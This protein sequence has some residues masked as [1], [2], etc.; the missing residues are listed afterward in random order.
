MKTETKNIRKLGSQTFFCYLLLYLYF[1]NH[2]NQWDDENEKREQKTA[3]PVWSHAPHIQMKVRIQME[4]SDR[5]HVLRL[6]SHAPPTSKVRRLGRGRFP[7]FP[8]SITSIWVV[9]VV[10]VNMFTVTELSLLINIEGFFFFF[11]CL[12]HLILPSMYYYCI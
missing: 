12:N 8:G 2:V 5:G 3:E 4:D 9:F 1:G 6:N 7:D 10:H 11:M